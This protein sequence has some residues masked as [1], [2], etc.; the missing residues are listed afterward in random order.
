MLEA[1]KMEQTPMKSDQNVKKA[2]WER[3]INDLAHIITEQ[4]S[5]QRLL[6][7]RKKIYEL[8]T[9]CI[10]P[11]T[12]LKNLTFQILKRVDEVC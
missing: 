3:F 11:E 12:I 10:P 7:A 1:C 5:A 8:L 2:D 9:N 4:Q 6:D